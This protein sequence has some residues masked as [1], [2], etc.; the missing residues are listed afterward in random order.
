MIVFA[1]LDHNNNSKLSVFLKVAN[2]EKMR[3]I[4]SLAGRRHVV[5]ICG[6]I[7]GDY[8]QTCFIKSYSFQ[9]AVF[10]IFTL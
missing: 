4:D 5:G 10:A 6:R 7:N 1:A 3:T 8:A 2:M 9:C